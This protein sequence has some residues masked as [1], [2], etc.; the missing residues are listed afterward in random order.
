MLSVWSY[1]ILLLLGK[2]GPFITLLA[3]LQGWCILRLQNT[4]KKNKEADGSKSDLISDP[5]PVIQW[6]LFAVQLFFC[7]GHRCTFDGLR[8]GAAF[9][10]FDNFNIIRQGVLLALDTFG[11]SHILP[12]FGL[13]LLVTKKHPHVRY[14]KHRELFLLQ[15]VQVFLIYG[16]V[17]VIMVTFST[18]CVTI[19][20]RHL[21]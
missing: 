10:G 2:Q 16:L 9:I 17:S 4:L 8:Y 5:L 1:T 12:V 15:I 6:N 7:T 14:D 19:Q 21:M 20:R 18:I 3:V 11:V 13:P